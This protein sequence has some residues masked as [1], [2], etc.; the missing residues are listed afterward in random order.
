M[1]KEIGFASASHA[2]QMNRKEEGKEKP[3]S[4]VRVFA[5]G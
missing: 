5:G 4:I 2:M 1:D 3:S